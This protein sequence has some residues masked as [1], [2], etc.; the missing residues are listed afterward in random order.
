ME[1]NT[2][3]RLS[4]KTFF[5][6][7]A[8]NSL[9]AIFLTFAWFILTVVKTVGLESIPIFSNSDDIIL[10]ATKILDLL[11]VFGIFIVILAWIISILGT[12]LKHFTFHFM[13]NDHGIN[14]MQGLLHKQETTTPYKHIETID[15]NQPLI[16]R[17]FG[18]CRLHILTGEE[19]TNN[20]HNH[21][22]EIEF[23]IIEKSLAEEIKNKM[24][25]HI[26]DIRMH[27]SKDFVDGTE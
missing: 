27:R 4:W 15:I 6:V 19:D 14:I 25:T 11:I 12:L 7:L 21:K 20:P 2:Y 17:L 5:I 1:Y 13:L 22:S 8:Q 24:F 10:L 9:T 18:M 26:N 3:Q 23:P 16:Y